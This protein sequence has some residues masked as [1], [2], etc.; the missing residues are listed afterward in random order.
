MKGLLGGSLTQIRHQERGFES[1]QRNFI[2]RLNGVKLPNQMLFDQKSQ[3]YQTMNKK[4]QGFTL[5]RGDDGLEKGR[6]HTGLERARE[7]VHV[8]VCVRERECVCVRESV[9]V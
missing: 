2:T 1:Q 8:S 7:R 3:S 6:S 4:R 5:Q 9:C